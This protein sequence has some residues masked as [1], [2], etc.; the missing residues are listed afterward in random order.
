MTIFKPMKWIL[1][2][3]LILISC[4]NAQTTVYNPG[5]QG[6]DDGAG[7]AGIS[8]RVYLPSG[9]L[10]SAG[11]GSTQFRITVLGGSANAANTTTVGT[12]WFGR[13]ASASTL[14]FNGNQVEITWGGS[15]TFTN[16][17]VNSW[18]QTSDFMNFA[19]G[20]TFDPTQNYIL[21]FFFSGANQAV[22]QST[23]TVSG[24]EFQFN[25]NFSDTSGNT[26]A[27]TGWSPVSNTV[28]LLDTIQVQG[29]SG[30]VVVPRHTLTLM[31][32]GR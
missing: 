23:Y 3:W 27:G 15:T 5:G 29:G 1:F 9:V 19:G 26:N 31:G 6:G 14:N 25:N 13:A 30:P 20:E 2:A 8:F 4:A 16:T 10:I 11:A 32:V 28:Q 18:T 21:A 7:D 24:A 22:S 12:F 17:G